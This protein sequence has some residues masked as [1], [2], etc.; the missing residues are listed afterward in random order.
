M[1]RL[2][3]AFMYNGP[4]RDAERVT[5]YELQLQAQEANNQLGGLFSTLAE[6]VQI[7]LAV[8]KL[9]QVAPHMFADPAEEAEIERLAA[10]H[11]ELGLAVDHGD[12][13]VVPDQLQPVTQSVL[14]E[15][16]RNARKHAEPSAVTVGVDRGDGTFVLTVAN[17]GVAQTE[18]R[19]SGMGLRLAAIEAI[20]HGG[21][22]EFGCPRPGWWQVKLMV[23]DG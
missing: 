19:G 18:A 2:S 10:Q 9:R 22:L 8:L 5:M 7:P 20:Q 23:P 15:A 16:V 4:A 13:A 21:I 3:R 6:S 1:Q 12:P 14:I 17:D 11:P